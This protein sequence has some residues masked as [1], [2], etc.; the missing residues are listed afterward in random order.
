MSHAGR[1]LVA[2]PLIGDP[3]FE[4]T[5]VLVLAHGPDGAFGVVLNR[6]SDT[7]VEEVA[8][9]WAGLAEA[10]GVVFV[11]GPVGRDA[12]LG[13]GRS[14]DLVPEGDLLV[15]GCTTVD[16]HRPPDDPSLR[17]RAVRLYA[18]S[19][20][21]AAGQLDDEIEEG[22]WWVADAA[23]DDLLTAD[24]DALWARVLRRQRGEV[25]WFANHPRDPSAN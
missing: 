17:W 8:P 16:L 20:G 9:E 21:W 11:G 24:P 14:D 4:R 23:F 3:T 13:L 25:A 1:L 7:R 19:A 5:V 22:A 12:V 18:G 2:T 6:P 15:G 10:P